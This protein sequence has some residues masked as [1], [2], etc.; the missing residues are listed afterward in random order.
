L[1][2]PE[3]VKPV[4]R[5]VSELRIEFG[6]GYRIYFARRDKTVIILLCGGDKSTQ[7]KD[8]ETAKRLAADWSGE[9]G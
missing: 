3:D 6:P 2:M 9:D 8:I 1:G 5:G 7:M 4:G